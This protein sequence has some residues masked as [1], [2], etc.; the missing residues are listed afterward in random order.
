M[1]F[2]DRMKAHRDQKSFPGCH[3]TKNVCVRIN[4]SQEG[5]SE[6]QKRVLRVAEE[7]LVEELKAKLPANRTKE[8]M[9]SQFCDEHLDKISMLEEENK[10]LKEQIEQMKEKEK[11]VTPT[12]KISPSQD[13]IDEETK[14]LTGSTF[15]NRILEMACSNL[16][17]VIK[18]LKAQM[19]ETQ[20]LEMP[21][22]SA[23]PSA[24]TSDDDEQ[25]TTQNCKKLEKKIDQQDQM[26]EVQKVETSASST[27]SSSTDNTTEESQDQTKINDKKQIHNLCLNLAER[28]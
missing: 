4:I 3:S 2:E 14:S 26:K 28:N 15:S 21:D 25:K 23:M 7:E 5:M 27:I 24:Q 19:D 22:F 1:S 10:K 9:N 13:Y 20:E 18:D 6:Q 8:K 11:V 16:E 12:L 17:K